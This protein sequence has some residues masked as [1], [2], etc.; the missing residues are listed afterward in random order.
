MK[1]FLSFIISVLLVSAVLV[2]CQ[3]KYYNDS[4]LNVPNFNGTMMQ[5]LES[6]PVLFDTL[7]EVIKIAKLENYFRDSAFTFF[8]PADSSIRKTIL[9]FN[10]QLKKSG[11]DTVSALT[12]IKPEFWRSTLMM[13]MFRSVK[14]LEDYPQL[15]L[16]NKQAFPGEFSRS[17]SGR[18]MNV[19]AVFTDAGGV[20]Y[21][22]YR[23]LNIAYIPSESAPFN[24]WTFCKIATCN[25]KPVN[26][27][28]HVLAY[29]N[30]Y[31]GFD[32]YQ[33]YLQARY[34]GFE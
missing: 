19:G 29:T 9:S 15:D 1:V 4:G 26:G 2:G 20:K 12:N 5:Y 16:N 30:H 8:A 33:A 24:S 14:G 34:Y 10:D 13:Y 25:L 6:N 18:I 31:F 22:G 17:I 7:V 3:K 11:Q 27:I 28:V 23:Y 21:K 32:D